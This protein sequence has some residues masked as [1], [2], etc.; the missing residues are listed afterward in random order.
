MAAI[1]ESRLLKV[2]KWME[3]GKIEALL[4]EDPIDL[5]YLTGEKVSVGK[6]L[7]N[8]D[9]PLFFV[10]G[11][12]FERVK[13]RSPC[14]VKLLDAFS[15][16]SVKQLY[17]D[18]SWTSFERYLDYQKKFPQVTWIG[19]SKPLQELRM[20]KE[21]GEIEKLKK[22][23]GLTFLGYQHLLTLLKEGIEEKELALEFE[24]FCKKRGADGLSFDP[25][26]AFGEN[27]AYPH[28]R[29][30]RARLKK[31]QIIQFDL[32]AVID[33]YA[34]DFS[35]AFFFGKADPKLEALYQTVKEAQKKAVSLVK[36]GAPIRA[37]EEAVREIF[38]EKNLESLFVHS[39]GHGIGLETHEPPRIRVGEERKLEPGM[40]FTIEPGLYLPGVGGARYEDMVVVTET[41]AENF[42]SEERS[43]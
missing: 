11:R 28:Y 41:G 7:F 19:L 40:V 14:P 32:G 37:L 29:A 3:K 23:A 27:S 10:D 42:F 25:I 30:G 13:K 36:P 31:N 39:L 12:Y 17:F 33:S 18:S 20:I 6:L 9:G 16:L 4:I 35:R 38:K 5:F 26:I 21:K 8:K 24:F 22:A 34:G 15:L 2:F 43:C 1:E